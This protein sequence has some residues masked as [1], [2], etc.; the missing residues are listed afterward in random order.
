MDKN[1]VIQKITECG[2]IAVLRTDSAQHAVKIA[3]ACAEAGITAIEVTFTVPGALRVIRKLISAYN[4]DEVIIGAGT[5]LDP[6]TARSA[7]LE[8]ASYIVSPCFNHE[9][10]KMCNRYQIACM[11]GAM[12]IREVVECM[13]AGADIVKVFPGELF[14]PR[15]VK[16]IKGPLP[17]AKLVPTGGINLDNVADW[18]KAGSLAVGVGSV[19]T[20]AAEDE[21]YKRVTQIGKQFI[22]KIKEARN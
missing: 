2:I 21:D 13:V 18:I 11:P 5:V 20:G 15:I 8:G 7:I 10:V 16:A 17:Y 12:T 4:K 6:E 3:D 1:A 22:E 14:G 9:T 19:L